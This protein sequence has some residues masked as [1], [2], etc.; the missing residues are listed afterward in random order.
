MISLK[1]KLLKAIF[2]HDTVG[3]LSIAKDF[4]TEFGKD[5]L[6]NIQIAYDCL[7]RSKRQLYITLGTSPKTH[8]Q[9][10]LLI[11]KQ[12]FKLH[13]VEIPASQLK[14]GMILIGDITEWNV[15]TVL[16]ENDTVNV[17]VKH[18]DFITLTLSMPKQQSVTIKAEINLIYPA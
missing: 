12:Y 14:T 3:A 9:Y 5:Q 1:Q 7:D 4:Y 15:L 2:D 11:L 6:R 8:C 18:K 13:G 16:C 10:A 17:L